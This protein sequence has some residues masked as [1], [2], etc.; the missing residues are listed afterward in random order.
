[1]TATRLLYRIRPPI[2]FEHD[3]AGMTGYIVGGDDTTYTLSLSCQPGQEIAVP[4]SW[5]VLV[6]TTPE[7]AADA[8][9][10]LALTE[11]ERLVS[12]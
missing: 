4:R 2:P 1:M 11:R 5:V 12:R 10:R 3:Y 6:P 9:K 7:S 8:R